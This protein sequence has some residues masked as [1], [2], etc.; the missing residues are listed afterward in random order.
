MKNLKITERDYLKA[1]RKASR[2]EEIA[3]FGKPLPKSKVHKSKKIYDRK[4]AKAETETQ[5]NFL[6]VVT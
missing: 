4:K 3:S 1:N 2:E 6:S 5:P